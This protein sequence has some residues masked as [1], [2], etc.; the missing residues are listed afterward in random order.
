M[1]DAELRHCPFYA[2]G[3]W[4]EPSSGNWF[5]SYDPTSGTAWARVAL[6]G[7]ADVGLA[8]EAA[9]SAFIETSLLR[10]NAR[11]RGRMLH[12]MAEA[13]RRRAAHL[14]A[15]ETRDNGKPYGGMLDALQGWLTDSFDYY[16]GLADKIEGAV[17]PADVPDT[18]NYTTR[19]PFGVVACITA[20]NSPLLI[21]IW[22]ISAAI[23]AGNAV[24]LKPSEHASVSTL[25]LMEVLEE[26]DLPP[27]LINVVTGLGPE[28]GEALVR[29]P[30]V[31][32]ISF[33]GGVAGG[34]AVARAAGDA[35]KPT[36]LEL[37]G[38]SPQIV[39]EDADLDLAAR[40]IAAGIFPPAGQSCIAGSRVLVA[41]SLHDALVERLVE[42]SSRARLGDPQDPKTHIG[43]ISNQ[44]HFERVSKAIAAAKAEGAT[45]V[46]DGAAVQPEGCD[47]WFIA[48]TIFTEVTPQM[49]VAREEIF[50]PVLAVLSVS[51]EDEAVAIANSSDYGLAAGI[52]TEDSARALRL[53][54]RIE[55]GTVYIN[56]YFGSAPQSPVGGYKQSGYGRENGIEGLLAFQQTKSVWLATTPYQPDPFS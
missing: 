40:G 34:R 48:P 4:H 29:H 11:A 7:E 44:P 26:A 47:G 21:A 28:T 52:W 2:A 37:G 6:C 24:V 20:W 42:I 55:A 49:S 5:D 31:R 50:G 38:K 56:T 1:G 32:L 54:A 46:L 9:R 45:C 3:A 19:E 22:K 16:G 18:L 12:R 13:V 8:V 35:T 43:P 25:A 53:A 27:G 33:T 41:D 17:V 23:A 10:T 36:I 39:L 15:I 14:A 30:H 51:D